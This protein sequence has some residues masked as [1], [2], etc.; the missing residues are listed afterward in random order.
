MLERVTRIAERSASRLSESRRDFFG[1]LGQG[2]LAVTSVLAGWLAVPGLLQGAALRACTTN[3]HCGRGQYCAKATG[4]CNGR[5]TC[6]PRPQ[7]CPQ[8]FLFGGLLGCDGK[9]YGNSCFAA[10]VGVNIAGPGPRPV[11]PVLR[12][13]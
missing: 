12:L 13:P 3:G 4:D 6:Q 5:G 10:S 7:I 11:V 9:I 8:Y 1:R 2:A